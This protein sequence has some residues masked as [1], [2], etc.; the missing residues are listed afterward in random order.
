MRGIELPDS[1]V[2]RQ[3][4]WFFSA[5]TD[6]RPEQPA[7]EIEERFTASFLSQVSADRVCQIMTQA[8]PLLRGAE[9][10]RVDALSPTSMVVE[11]A[12]AGMTWRATCLVDAEAPN[13]I[14]SLFLQNVPSGTAASAGPVSADGGSD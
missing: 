7:E 14:S 2:G 12:A 4:A 10:V 9:V 3:L 8:G 6:E 5:C 13:R 11:V 1:P